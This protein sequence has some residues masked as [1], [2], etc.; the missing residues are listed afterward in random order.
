M[1]KPCPTCGG[2]TDYLQEQ[3]TALREAA[4]EFIA[5]VD[6]GNAHSVHSY[7]RFKDALALKGRTK[8]TLN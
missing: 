3:L 1:N 4:I 6:A 5:K 8:E 7:G 2:T